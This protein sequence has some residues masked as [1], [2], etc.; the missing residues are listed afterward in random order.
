MKAHFFD[1]TFINV[2]SK[3]KLQE[4]KADFYNCVDLTQMH[5][6]STE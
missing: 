6:L 3:D 5:Y 2:L 1:I 4:N